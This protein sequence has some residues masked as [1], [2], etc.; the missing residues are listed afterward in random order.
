[1]NNGDMAMGVMLANS[2]R[3]CLNAAPP[4]FIGSAAFL[5]GGKVRWIKECIY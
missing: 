5:R 3:I 1:M 2:H 4:V